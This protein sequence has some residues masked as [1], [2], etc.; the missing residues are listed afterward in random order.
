MAKKYVDKEYLLDQFKNYDRLVAEPKYVGAGS[1]A[2]TAPGKIASSSS[3]G[4][5]AKYARQDHTHGIDLATGDNNGQV[6]IA[7]TNVTVKGLDT[8]AYTKSTDYLGTSLKGANNGVAELDENGKVPS[9]QLPS[10]VDDVMEY[11]AMANF[12]ATG[13]AGKIYVDISTNKS[14]RGGGSSYVLIA[15]SLALGTTS[16]TA[17]RGDRGNSAYK[18]AVTNKGEAFASGLYKITTN[19]EGHVTNATAVV[20]ADITDLGIPEYIPA[21][22]YV[23]TCESAADTQIKVV[24]I[25]SDQ[26]FT[27][28]D[29][30]SIYVKFT[31][32][33][34]F[35]ATASD[36]VQLNVNNTGAKDIYFKNSNANTGVNAYYYGTAGYYIKYIYDGSYW[37]W[38]GK[39]DDTDTNT[40]YSVVT[41]AELTAGTS[42]GKRIIQ[43]S[44]F[45]PTLKTI[46]QGSDIDTANN[47]VAFTE[48]STRANIATGENHKTLFGKIAK[49]FSDLKAVAFTGS[50]SDLSN[51]PYVPPAG[52]YYGVCASTAGNQI[53]EVTVSSDQNFV[54]TVGAE[55]YVKFVNSNTFSATATNHIM[56]NVNNTGA[57]DIFGGKSN[58]NTG[59]N[60]SY[61][62][63]AGY[64]IKYLYDGTYWVWSGKSTDSNTTYSA[65]SQSELLAGTASDARTIKAST[66]K[67]AI[68][69]LITSKVV[70]TPD[71]YHEIVGTVSGTSATITLSKANIQSGVSC[72]GHIVLGGASNVSYQ[73]LIIV[74]AMSTIPTLAVVY[75]DSVIQS[76]T[77]THTTGTDWTMTITIQSSQSINTCKLFYPQA[78][79][80]MA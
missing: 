66:F 20:K 65:M 8:A 9:S 39:S 31:N 36:H 22:S 24:T 21:G 11:D 77:E 12:P 50:Y 58:T 75:K 69:A 48:A 70:N 25:S 59:T 3:V 78:S 56:L 52:C 18:H 43:P 37:V 15:S 51:T 53:K 34:T 45:T 1:A 14:Y 47:T 35:S 62:G 76:I 32:T 38:A 13:E 46:I 80:I 28:V 49:F 2:T 57:I 79:T 26:N 17:Y 55:V 40:T 7:G 4:T 54:L 27:L 42:T 73:V 19:S 5:S 67:P 33:N 41:A 10:Y 6:K 61:Y 63:A 64:Y 30:A 29:G 44:T 72:V 16:S 23:G 74:A 60:T 71:T 68:E